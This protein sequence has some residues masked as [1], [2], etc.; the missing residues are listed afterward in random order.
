MGVDHL[1]TLNYAIIIVETKVIAI[2]VPCLGAV[3]TLRISMG[4]N[5][6]H[7]LLSSFISCYDASLPIQLRSCVATHFIRL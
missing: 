6:E 2:P 1:S 4:Q 5:G 3:S 7:A